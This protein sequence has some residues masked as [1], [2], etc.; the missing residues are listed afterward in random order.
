VDCEGPSYLG[1]LLQR[2]GREVEIVHVYRNDPLPKIIDN[3]A[4]GLIFLGGPMSVN[5]ELP[6]LAEETALIRQARGRGLPM[7]G[8]CL[9]AQL[10]SKALGGTVQKNP[11]KEIGWLD[12][13]PTDEALRWAPG[14]PAVIRA[15]HWHGETF[16]L[17]VGSQRLFESTACRNQGFVLDNVLGLQFHLEIAAED[18]D[19]WATA[20]DPE[21]A[22][23]SPTVQTRA[24]M[25][26]DLPRRMSHLHRVADLVFERW[27][28]SCGGAR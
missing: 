3:G 4:A 6:W 14:L 27:I 13:R 20:Y 28:D 15:F 7:L 22:H 5:D 23:P 19:R 18:V 9:G 24:Q 16:S 11:V 1:R 25:T 10:L 17:P 12:V 2:H 26:E 21:I 8:I